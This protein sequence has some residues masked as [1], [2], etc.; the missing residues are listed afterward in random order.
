L[1][2]VKVRQTESKHPS[3]KLTKKWRAAIVSKSRD[4]VSRAGT[5]SEKMKET[6]E[7]DQSICAGKSCPPKGAQVNGGSHEADECKQPCED[8]AVPGGQTLNRAASRRDRVEPKASPAY[9][10]HQTN[11]GFAWDTSDFC[12]A[13]SLVTFETSTVA[14]PACQ[15]ISKPDDVMMVLGRRRSNGELAS[16]RNATVSLS[17]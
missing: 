3:T 5:G 17:H 10:N 9:F 6:F 13:I 2:W 12:R 11:T 8:H 14:H 4:Q 1:T 7:P 15:M 16:G